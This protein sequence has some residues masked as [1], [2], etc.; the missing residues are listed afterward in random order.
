MAENLAAIDIGTNSIHLVVARF[1]DERPLRGDRRRE[2]GRAPRLER[3]RHEGARARRHRPWHR[4]AHPLPPGGRH[5]RRPRSAPSPPAR[6][7][8]P[9]T[10]RSSSAGPATRPASRSRSSPASRRPASSTSASCRPSRSST[11]RLLLIDIGGGST[12]VLVGQRGETLAVRSFKLGAIRLTRRF[13]QT[14]RLHP[15]AVDACRRFVRS[16]LAPMAREV[17]RLGFE[18]AVGSSGTIEAVAAMAH[19]QRRHE[20]HAALAH[21]R[22]RH[23]QGGRGASSKRLAAAPTVAKRRE[24]PGARARPGRHHP[25]RAPSS[26]SRPW[27][28]F[29]IDELVVSDYAL[30][31]GVLLDALPAPPRRRAAPPARPAPTQRRPPGRDDGR[32]AR[33]LG[34]RR[35]A[36]ARPLRRDRALPRPRRRRPRAARGRRPAGQRGPVRLPQQAPQ[37]HATT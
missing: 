33:A 35:R 37:A 31:E 23:P 10:P 4:R 6:C 34:P 13:F 27:P 24:L 5:L 14:D 8:R 12:E 25:R 30:R 7:A 16:M 22:H 11:R 17:E 21:Q 3:R 9:R 36:G 26:S 20:P 15:G 28:L 2:G 32:G 29:G 19:A 18:V 1:D